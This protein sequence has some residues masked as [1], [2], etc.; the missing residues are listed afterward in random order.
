MSVE[1]MSFSAHADA[2]GIMQLIQYCEPRHVMLVHGEAVKMKFLREKIREEF[3]IE[4]YHPANGETCVITTPVKIPVDASLALLK[5]EAKRYNA[6]PPDPKRRRIIHGVLVMR[7]NRI[8]LMDVDEVCKEA[9]INRHILRFTSTVKLDDGD[10]IIRTSE[11]LFRLL[12]DK[13]TDWNVTLKDT[14]D[15]IAIESVEIKIEES[16]EKANNQ[17]VLSVSWTNQDEDLGSY[18][19]GLLQNMG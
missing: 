12:Q 13:L 4:C 2:K 11:K 18:V 19:L 6:Q 3:R 9:G 14:G 16:P 8:S 7:D 5:A 1:Y 15:A 10:P 17:K